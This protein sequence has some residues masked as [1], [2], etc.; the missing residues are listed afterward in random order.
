MTKKLLTQIED[1]KAGQIKYIFTAVLPVFAF[2]IIVFVYALN[3][4]YTKYGTEV[5]NFLHPSSTPS[6]TATQTLTPTATSTSMPTST[7]SPTPTPLP[8]MII[9][10][11]ANISVYDLPSASSYQSPYLEKGALLKL[12]RYCRRGS[13]YWVLVPYNNAARGYG[14][15][16]FDSS[17]TYGN[18]LIE[19]SYMG[20]KGQ[21]L[22]S[23]LDQRKDLKSDC[24]ISLETPV[25]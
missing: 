15:L 13:D 1:K 6:P 18:L 11:T 16:K 5:E 24:P 10:N 22:T 21:L 25:P 23:L 4:T 3:S 17:Y 8:I 2:L 12:V 7:I 20:Y 9:I 14:W 19:D